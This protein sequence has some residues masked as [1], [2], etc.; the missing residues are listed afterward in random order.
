MRTMKPNRIFALTE[1]HP[2]QVARIHTLSDAFAQRERFS[3]LG[4]TPGAEIRILRTAL[5]G[6]PIEILVRGVRYGLRR[7]DAKN[8]LVSLL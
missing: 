8:I 2:D 3:E 7:D 1:L 6:D 4:F 5:F